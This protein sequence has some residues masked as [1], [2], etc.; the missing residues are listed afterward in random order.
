MELEKKNKEKNRIKFEIGGK[1]G[2]LK[3]Y[4]RNTYKSEKPKPYRTRPNTNKTNQV[5]AV[6]EAG[7]TDD[8]VSVDK[9]RDVLLD[10]GV[11][12]DLLTDAWRW[13]VGEYLEV[14]ND[15]IKKKNKIKM[16]E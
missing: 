7:T 5:H 4:T 14:C 10:P 16:R 2:E 13:R 11:D 3:I 9:R 6:D 8:V 1:K 15:K 12:C